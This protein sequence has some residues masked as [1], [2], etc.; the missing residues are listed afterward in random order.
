MNE[1]KSVAKYLSKKKN[2]LNIKRKCLVFVSKILICIVFLLIF[3]IVLKKDENGNQLIYKYLYE[4]NINF[5]SIN[6][7][8]QK[9]F[10]DILP[11]Q[12]IA[13]EPIKQVFSEKITYTNA[14]IYKNGVNLEVSNNYL[15]PILESGVVVFIGQKDDFNNTVIIQQVDGTNVW[16]GNIDNLNVNL[17]DYVSKGEFLGESIDNNLYMLFEKDGEYLDYKNYL[18]KN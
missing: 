10:G 1:Y 16:Y 13:N 8:Y 9:Y 4:N 18:D 3:L 2:S 12:S 7:L 5:A 15:V 14:S 11:L 17:Y 6:N